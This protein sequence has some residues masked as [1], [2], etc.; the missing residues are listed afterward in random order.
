MNS[1]DKLV[2]SGFLI[3]S[4]LAAPVSAAESDNPAPGTAIIRIELQVG[5]LSVEIR[6]APLHRVLSEIGKMA[7]FKTI[8]VANPPDLPLVNTSFQNLAVNAAVERILADTSHIV[9]YSQ[10]DDGTHRRVI[11]Q[12][13]VL[14]RGVSGADTSERILLD[15]DLQHEEALKRS[16]A[17]LRVT[18]QPGGEPILVKLTGMLKA[19]PD[20]LVRSRAAIALGAL[21]DERAVVDLETA[22]LDAHFSVRAQSITALGQIGGERVT[23]ILGNIL[24]NDDIAS[25]ERVMAAQAFGNRIPKPPEAISRLA[26]AIAMNR[27]AWRRAKRHH[28]PWRLLVARNPALR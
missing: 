24:L 26:P 8:L 20:P 18:Q 21:G 25:V 23:S 15:E 5:L 17:V 19:D 28:Y 1:F 11:S 27:C 13:W 2:L 9:F 7:G 12:L 10:T 16:E 14:G 22:L 4:S 3:V 6:A